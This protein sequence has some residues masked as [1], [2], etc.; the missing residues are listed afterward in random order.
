MQ[1]A[2]G[3][4]AAGRPV[5]VRPGERMPVDGVVHRRRSEIDESLVTG[6][7]VAAR[8]P[9]GAD[10]LCRH[11][12]FRGALHIRVRAAGAG[13]LLDEIE[14]LLKGARARSRATAPRRPGGAALCAGRS[15]D[16]GADGDRLAARRRVAAR[17]DHHGDRRAHHHLSL[18]VGAG[19]PAVQVVAAGA[20]FRSGVLLNAGDAIERLAE[21]DTVVFDKTGTLTLP[22]PR[23]VNAADDRSRICSSGGAAG[24]VQPPSAGH[25][26]GA[27]GAR[28]RCPIDGAVEEPGRG[29]R[30]RA[31]TASRRGSAASLSAASR[32][33]AGS[34]PATRRLA[35]RV[36]SWR[37]RGRLLRPAESCGPT[38][39]GG[40]NRLQRRGLDLRIL[41][42]D[43]AEAVRAGRRGA[44]R[45]A[46]AGRLRPAE[47]IAV[48]RGACRR[49][50]AAC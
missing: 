26:A 11:V 13:T 4:A 38:R 12:E 49:K 50:A 10:D 24:A 5:L 25:G 20:L 35:H 43:R 8:S 3:G 30:A 23:V 40:R 14:R 28:A 44:R 6:E 2:G 27:R 47:K 1:R 45:R 19:V 39:R 46:M 32:R 7:T 34:T 48:H 21:V 9:P 33:R 31:S 37:P 22:E 15:F 18:R 17:C 29:V 36:P 42:G 41:S 16:R